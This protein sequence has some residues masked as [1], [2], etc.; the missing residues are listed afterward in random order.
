MSYAFTPD[1]KSIRKPT[2]CVL[3]LLRCAGGACAHEG[4]EQAPG[5]L[6]VLSGPEARTLSWTRGSRAS[7]F[8]TTAVSSV[9]VRCLPPYPTSLPRAERGGDNECMA[10]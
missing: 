5:P 7:R 2:V 9:P 3:P 4:R 6:V 8:P 10:F 1:T